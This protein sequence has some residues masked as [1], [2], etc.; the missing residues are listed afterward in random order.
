MI[1]SVISPGRRLVGYGTVGHLIA[2][3][4]V[5]T[6]PFFLFVSFTIWF[7][8]F[9]FFLFT[10]SNSFVTHVKSSG[11]ML[12]NTYTTFLKSLHQQLSWNPQA[13]SKGDKNE[14]IQTIWGQL[15]LAGCLHAYYMCITYIFKDLGF[16]FMTNVLFFTTKCAIILTEVY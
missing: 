8:F 16:F 14:H 6:W 15:G 4:R 12:K 11:H 10:T 5:K 13:Y 2:G 7:W 1:S 3:R 9:F